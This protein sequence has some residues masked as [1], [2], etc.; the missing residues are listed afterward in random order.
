MKNMRRE[1]VIPEINYDEP[2]EVIKHMPVV[3]NQET[4]KKF[5]KEEFIKA[6]KEGFKQMMRDG[7]FDRLERKLVQQAIAREKKQNGHLQQ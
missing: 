7:D 6:I 2:D 1:L 3:I 5:N 4:N